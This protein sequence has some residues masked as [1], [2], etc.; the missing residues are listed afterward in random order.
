MSMEGSSRQGWAALLEE[1]SRLESQHDVDLRA[2]AGELYA[3]AET[4]AGNAHL[5]RALGDRSRDAWPKRELAQRVLGSHVSPNAMRIIEAAVSERWRLDRDLMHAI[6]RAGHD[7]VLAAAQ[8]DGNLDQVERELLRAQKLFSSDEGLRDALHR[9]D[10]PREAKA[11]LVTNLL[12]GKVLPDTVWLAQRPVLNPRGRRYAA[13][14]WQILAQ[15]AR[16]RDKVTAL[17]TSATALD[18]DQVARLAAGLSKLYGH[19]IFVDA[20]VDPELVGGLYVKVGDEVID[21]TI[22]RRLAEAGRVLGA[23]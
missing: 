21:A 12:Q 13:V 20:T 8:R 10:I 2:V 7:L 11:E 5:S 16:L 6:E 4:F 18:E 19:E 9:I 15:A 3:V 14:V 22:D 1:L 17:V 23:V